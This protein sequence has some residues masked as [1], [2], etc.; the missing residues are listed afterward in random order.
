MD[1]V[2]LAVLAALWLALPSPIP[3]QRPAREMAV[4]IDDL[5]TV[6]V[7]PQSPESAAHLTAALLSGLRR[8]QVPAI[9]FVNEAKLYSEGALDARRLALLQQ[10]IDAGLELGNH[11]Y[12]HVDLH[13]VPAGSYIAEIERGDTM[14]RDLLRK[15]GRMPRF[16]RHP[17]LRT[18]RDAETR[19][20]VREFLTGRGYRIA[21][22]SIDNADYVF[23]AAFD[24]LT[25]A[26]DAAAAQNVRTAYIDYMEAVAAYYEQQSSRIVGREIR[27]I[28][29]MHANALN[30][31]AFDALA[32]RHEARGYRFVTLEHA[33]EDSAYA[34]KDEYFGPGGITWLHRWALTQKTPPSTFAGEPEVP[35]WVSRASEAS[36]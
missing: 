28:L 33:L 5:P 23:A 16:F 2:L 35:A 36:R 10:W 31:S 1:R 13:L 26:G 18:G 27:Q 25:A 30:A 11:T 12:S 3:A 29:L 24:R 34:M 8:Q 17:Y 21:P 4:T 20:A 32:A 22:V 19:T 7:V 6:S 15:A 14:T 9:G